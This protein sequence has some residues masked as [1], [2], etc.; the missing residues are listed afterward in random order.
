[1]GLQLRVAEESEHKQ[2]QKSFSFTRAYRGGR[3]VCGAYMCQRAPKL[4]LQRY[5]IIS[6]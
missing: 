2:W 1:M 6:E 3:G 4:G 5:N